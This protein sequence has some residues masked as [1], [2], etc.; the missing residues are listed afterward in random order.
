MGKKASKSHN[1]SETNLKIRQ[2]LPETS[3]LVSPEQISL[4]EGI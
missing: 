4:V 1:Y 3:E 2:A